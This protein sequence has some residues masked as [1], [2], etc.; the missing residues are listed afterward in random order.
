MEQQFQTQ[1]HDQLFQSTLGQ[2]SQIPQK[3][4]FFKKKLGFLKKLSQI[5]NKL[6]NINIKT[7]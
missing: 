4:L 7:T 5:I 1:N 2:F 3:N 6:M